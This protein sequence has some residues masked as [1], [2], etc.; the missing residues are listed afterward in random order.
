M[1]IDIWRMGKETEQMGFI[2]LLVF[3]CRSD[4]K[5]SDEERHSNF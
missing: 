1:K 5:I 2:R 4:K 3:L